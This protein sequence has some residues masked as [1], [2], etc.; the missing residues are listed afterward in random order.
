MVRS[1]LESEANMKMI[2]SVLLL[3]LLAGGSVHAI[4]ARAS[5]SEPASAAEAAEAL[6]A[7]LVPFKQSLMATLGEGLAKG[8]VA[9]VG[10][11]HLQAPGLVLDPLA[12][13]YE[14]GRASDRLRNPDNLAPS[15]VAPV[16]AEMLAD[17]TAAQGRTVRLADG[18]EG[19]LEP[20]RMAPMCLQCHGDSIAPQVRD[21]LDTRYPQDR[22]SDYAVGDLRGVF[23][24]V[25]T[26]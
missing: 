13:G 9:A 14:L 18:R 17:P 2:R 23:W 10:A 26:R 1:Y 16:M 15:W 19:Y 8:T 22:A 12:R 4:D 11:C 21:A 7:A 5:G 3:S 6:A 24:I 20:I 25:P